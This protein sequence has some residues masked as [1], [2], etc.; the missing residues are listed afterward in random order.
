MSIVYCDCA[1]CLNNDDGECSLNYI[2][3]RNAPGIDSFDYEA[4][5]ED[6]EEGDSE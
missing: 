3:S 1:D 6:Y 2:N 4:V 5:C